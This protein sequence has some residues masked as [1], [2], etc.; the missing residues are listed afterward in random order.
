MREPLKVT[1]DTLL[2]KVAKINYTGMTA[3]GPAALTSVAMAAQGKPGSSVVILTDGEANVGLGSMREEKE[4]KEFYKDVGIY[5]EENGVSI[6]IISIDGAEANVDTLSLMADLTGGSVERADPLSLIDDV[7]GMLAAANI[8]S[9]VSVKVKL[10]K[11][12]RFRNELAQYLSNQESLLERKFGNVTSESVFSFEYGLKPIADL[13]KIEDIDLEKLVKIPFQAQ[14]YY[15]AKDGSKYLRVIT[16]FLDVNN[17]REELEKK[18][19]F[20]I[21]SYNAMNKGTQM[22]KA[23]DLRQG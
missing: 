12:L 3:L 19:N 6:N 18:A 16:Q 4:A 13:L 21:L 1:K 11:C 17:D 20:D 10:H 5:A 14:I 23:G 15:T 7:E 9:K 22:P 8:A 2:A